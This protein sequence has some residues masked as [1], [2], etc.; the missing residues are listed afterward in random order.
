MLL[1]VTSM[2][3]LRRCHTPAFERDGDAVGQ[4]HVGEVTHREV[5]SDRQVDSRLLPGAHLTQG[6]LDHEEGDRC[7]QSGVL[8]ERDERV[9][10]LDAA[11]RVVPPDQRLDPQHFAA[12]HV[13]LG[14]V[15]EEELVVLDRRPQV[16]EDRESLRGV[17]V[18]IFVGVGAEPRPLPLGLVEGD[19]RA[20]HQGVDV[21]TVVRGERD[22]QAGL[23]H[24]AYAANRERLAQHRQQ[25][26]GDVLGHR[27]VG[28]VGKEH[29][30]LVTAESGDS[31]SLG[32]RVLEPVR[33][34]ADQLVTDLMAEGVVDL[35]E[36]VEVDHHDRQRLT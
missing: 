10:V 13:D 36:V 18:L 19:V 9:G 6:A 2:T 22:S 23:Y 14:L 20:T 31:G 24:E 30:E 8:G 34:L 25:V 15:D 11:C 32:S 5:D 28:D 33:H 29:R 26:G 12:R 1:S 27:Q 7:D 35:L 16:G 17:R 4:A 3:S 21:V